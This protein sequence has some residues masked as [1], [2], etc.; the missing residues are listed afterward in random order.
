MRFGSLPTIKVVM[1]S[2]NRVVVVDDESGFRRVVVAMLRRNGYDVQEASDA[3]SALFLLSEQT[4]CLV[5][6]LRMP[7][8]GGMDLF[9]RVRKLYPKLKVIFLTAYAQVADSVEA[10]KNGAFDYIE[11]GADLASIVAAVERAVKSFQSDQSSGYQPNLESVGDLGRFGMVGRGI[12]MEKIFQIISKV[13]FSS[14]TALIMGE[15][16]TGKELVCNAIHK[17]S[18]RNKG[19]FVKV[20]CA[21]IPHALVESELFGYER[22]AFTGAVQNKM[23]RF[24]LAHGGTLFLDEIAELPLSVQAKLLR[25]LQQ[26]EFERVGGVKTVRVDVRI[27]AATNQDLK[28]AVE[29]KSFREDLFYRLNVVP[30][31]LPP[32]RERSED[33]P[34]LVDHFISKLSLRLGL[35]TN[36]TVEPAVYK[37]FKT[38]PFPGNIR[39]LENI[40]ERIILLHEGENPISIHEIPLEIRGFVDSFALQG[41]SFLSSSKTSFE[42]LDESVDKEILFTDQYSGGL[43]QKV[44]LETERIEKELIQRTLQ[45]TFGNVTKAAK[46]L[47][48]SRKSLQNKMKELKLKEK[49]EK[50]S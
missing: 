38:Y 34:L 33:I 37:F 32:L 7:G 11:K 39:E 41:S 3:H 16:G 44:R 42:S 47:E 9:Y 18:P 36:L 26:A 15:S 2:S 29:Q 25:V 30:I 17:N 48:I 21:A 27:I 4:C 43:K 22:G 8:L 20:N 10:V 13:A 31:V 46:H 28:K 49:T 50:N 19:P 45:S 6:D 1:N 40:I 12:A 5:T 14:T 23:G 35:K 24:E